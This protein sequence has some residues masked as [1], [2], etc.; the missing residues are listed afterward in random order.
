[1]WGVRGRARS[2]PRLL[3][4]WAGY[5]GRC[6]ASGVGRS[7]TP[8]C[9]PSGRAAGAGV[10]RPGSDALPPPTA[11]PLGGLPGPVWGVRGRARSDPRLLALWAGCRGRCGASRVGRS[12]TPDCPPFGRAAGDGV[13][14]PGSD[15]LPPPTARPLG[16]LPGPVWGVQGRALSHPRLLALWAGCR[17]RCG[18]SGVGRSPTPDCPPSGRAAGAGVGRPGSGTLPLPTARPLGGLPGPVW[19]VRGRTL[20][21]PRLPALWAGCRGRCGASGVGRSRTPDCPP[22]GRAAG[23]GVGRPGSGPLLARTARPL[24]GLPGPVWGVR[25]RTLSHPRLPSLWAGCRC[26]CGASGVGRAPTPD[27]SPSGRAAGAG[28]GRPGSGALPP[29][30][31]R[32]LGGLPVPVWGVRGRTLSHPR[33]PAL[34]AGCRVRCGASG[35]GRSPTPDCPPSGRAAGAG[36]GRQGSDAPP[37]PTARPLGGLPGPVWGVRGRAL[38]HSQLPALWAGCR[39]RCGASGVGRSPTPDCPP[40]GRAAWAGVGRPGSGALPPP[41]ARPLGGLPGPVWGVRGRALSHPRLLALWAGCRGRGG[42]SRVGRP[43][44][45][46]CPPSGRAARAGV[47]CLGSGA[48]PT[49]TARPLGGLPGPAWGVRGRTLSHPQLPALWAGCRGRSGASGVGRAPTPDCSPSGRAAGAGEGR[50]GSGALPPPAARPLGGLPVPVWGVRGRTLCHPR[51]P[52]LWAGC[53]RRCGASGVGR[54]P[55]PDCPPSGRAAGAG[56]GRPGSGALP[57]PTARPLGGLPGPVWGI[58]GRTL[59]HSQLPALWPGCLGRCGA[60]WVG[61]AP[62]PDCPPSGRA[63]GARVGRPGSGA[64]PPPTARPLGGLPGPVWGVRGRTPFQPRL[65]ALWAGCRGRCGASGVGRS[66]TPDCP[67]SGQAAGAGV[68]RPGSGALPLPTA[69]P[70]GGLPGPV[71][72]VLGRARSHPRMPALWAGCWGPC[73]ASGVGRSPTPDCSPS[74]RAAGAGVGRPGSDALPPPTA[75]PLGGLPRPVW[76]V[77][78]RALSR[79]RLLALWAGCRG[80]CGESGVGRSPTADCPPSGRAAGAGVGRPGSDTPPPPTARPLGGLP[81]PV[82]GVRGRALSQPRLLTLWAGCRGRCGAARVGRPSTPDCPPSGRAAGAGVG[83]PGSDT[84]PPRTAR[85]LGGLPGPVWGVRGR[86]LP[87]PRL[88]ALWAGCRGPCGASGVGR[89]P[90]PDCPPSGRAAWAGVGRPGSGALPPPTARP[91]GGL[92]R[93]VWGVRGRALSRPRLLALWAGCRGRCGACGV[94]RPSNPDCPPSVRAARASVGCPGSGALPPRTARPLGGLPGPVWGVRGRT[95]SDPPLPALLAACQGPCGASGVGRS[96]TPDCSHSGRAARAGVGRP[97]SGALPPPTARPLGGLPGQVWGVRGRTLSH[98]RLPALWAG[99]RGGVGR[100]GSGDLPPPTACPLGGLPG[101]VWGVRGRTLSHPRLPALWAGC[102]GRCGASG[103]GRSPTPE[104]SPSGR[105]AGAG[106]GRLGSDALPPPTARPLGGLPGPVWGVRGRAL[107]HSRLPALWAG[108]RGRC[109][110]SGVGRSPTPDCPPSGRAAGAGVGRPGS[111]AL[112]PPTSRPLGGLPGPVWGVRGRTPSQPRLPALWAGCQGRCGA[113]GVGRSPIPDCSPFGR[114]AGAGVGRPGS[115]A[116]PPPTARPLGGLPGPVWGVWGRTLSHPRLPALWAGCRGWCGA[117]GVGRSPTPTARPLGGLPAPVW[118]VRGR[119]LP[120]PRLPALWAGCRGRCGASGVGHSPTPDC[121]PSGRAAGPVWGVRGRTLSHSRLPALWAGCRGRCGA[122]GVARSPDPDCSP[123]GRAA[124]AGVGR[125]WSDALPTPTARPLCGLPWPVWGVWGRALSDPRLLALWAGCRGRCGAS[126]VGRSP[127]PDCPPSGRAARARVGRPGSGALP[128]MTARTLG[129]LPGQTW[130]VRGRTLS[131]CRLPALW[132]GCRGRCGASGVGRSPTP[133]CSPSGRA[134]RAGVGRPGSD[135]LPPPTARPLGGLPGRCGASGVGRSPTPDCLPS[136]RAAG[137]GVGRPGSGALPP[138]TARP[139]G[140]LPG[141]VW[142]VRGRA[143]SHPR[144]LALWE[145]CRGRCGASGVGRSPTPDCPPSGRAS[146]AGVGRPGSGALPLPTARPLGGLPGQV[147]GV[148]GRTL[149]HSRLLALWPGCRGRCGASGVG[150]SPTADCP[151]SGR[152]A[153]AGV[154]RPG[155]DALPPPTARPLG[156]LPGPV[157]GVQGRAL[158]HPRLPAL[159]AGCRRRCGASGVGHSPTPDCPPSGR[160]AGAGVGRPGSDTPPPPTARSLGGLP[161]PV[162][163]VRGRTLSHSRLPALWAGCLGRCGASGVG[164]A[165]TPDCP[166]SGRAAGADVGRPRSGALPTPTARPLGGLPGPVWGVRGRTP[167]QPRLPALCAGCQGQCRMSGVGRSPSPD[168]SPSGRAAGAGVGRLGSDALPSPNARPLGGLPGP[169]WGVRG[170]AL[171]QPRLLALW[172]GCRGPCGASGVRRSPTPDCLPSGRPAGAGVGSLGS[173]ALPPPTAR[174]LGGLPRPVWGVRGRALSHSRLLALWEGCRGR[175]GWFGVGRSPTP[176]CPPSGRASGAGVGRPGSGALP[177]PTARPLG[178]LPGQVWGVRG[179]TLSHSRLPALWAG[180][181][182]R[183]GASGV[184]RAPTPDCSPSGRAA[185]AGVGRPGSGALPFPTARPLG[186]LPEPVWG[187]RGRTPS[188]TQLP[189]IWAGCQGRC[190]ASGVGR[191]PTPDC[192]PSG[193][194]DGAVVGRPGSGALPPPTARPL[195]GLPGPVWGVRGRALSHRRLPALWAGCR[196]RCGASGVGR[197]PSPDCPP[198]GRATG[199]GVGRP[200]SGALSPPTARPLGGLPGPQW[201]VRGR[202]LSHPRLSALWAGCRGRCG[203]S[204]WG[205]SPTPDCSPFGR[206]AGAGVGRPGSGAL[207]PPTARPLGGLPG[208]QWGVRGRALSHPRLPAL[209]AG[210]RRR[211][212]ASGVGHSPT[213][214]C[215]PSGRAAGAGVGRR[216]SDT[217][218]LPT[219]RPLGGPPG[220]V[221]GVRGRTLPHSR[222]PALWAGCRGRCGASWVGRAPAPDCPPSGRAAGAGVGRPGSGAL[223]TPTAC[224]LCRLPGPVWGV[225]GRVLSHPRLL[226]LLAGCRGRCGASGVGRSPTPDCP[227]SRRAARARVGRPGSGALPPPTARTLG[228]LPGQVWGV[229]GRTLSHCRLPALWA[230]CRGRCGASGVGRSPTPDC[231]PSGR[232]AG[233]GVGR[234]GSDALPPRTAHPLGGLP[235]RCGA[236]GVGRS[237]TPDCLPSG[238]AAGDGVERPGSDALPPPTAR[239]LGGLPGPVW[240]IWGRALS[241]PRLLA[242]WAGCRGRCGAS[243]VGRSPAPDCPPSGWAAG[244]GVR[245]PGSDALPL[246]TARPLG[247]LPVPVWGVRGWAR[248]HPRLLALWAGC[249]GRCGAFGVGRSPTPDCS[250]SGRAAGCNNSGLPFRLDSRD[251]LQMLVRSRVPL[252]W[253]LAAE[254]A[255]LIR[256]GAERARQFSMC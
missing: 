107:S 29:P 147:W 159:W 248:S 77:W 109:G 36:V 172:A 162:W 150:R 49:P 61:R 22:S 242:L 219:A 138:P 171:S 227:P 11:G 156:R 224:P 251:Q 205:R 30:T 76:G 179:R 124:G 66:P 173:D 165:P 63:A 158:S 72:G 230:G 89:S 126:G 209:W 163:G 208:P 92:P 5:R 40:S 18:A 132:A 223:R 86:T 148:R 213:P 20:S 218:P 70:L 187:V 120:H 19:G 196:G 88:P 127:C 115:G 105:A 52:A 103:V 169:V 48:L 35:V 152:A 214:D 13:G 180:C 195:G 81:G 60:S 113:S 161:G 235:G 207:S 232:A 198:S 12:P 102:R 246:P 33:L 149:S 83:R 117:S 104:C 121:P 244:A 160:A 47:G 203:A 222:L 82:W 247:G 157:W 239:P 210:C 204:G 58:R 78:G 225:R 238:R 141:P 31:A 228:G 91:L 97:G 237:P 137:A 28:V 130:G 87:H 193:R 234:P 101:P 53:R 139:L 202:A 135:A 192:S 3:A 56:V 206:A 50:P 151:P 93:P 136:G 255:S 190:G 168:C 116:L 15:A 32:P 194:A 197:S 85:P 122:S 74:G 231:S 96:P 46:D 164:R 106:V 254:V 119:T 4:L 23:A 175:C 2:H 155:S 189:A 125:P 154:G 118:G 182:C 14:R 69:R 17:G 95:L 57:L 1:M 178:G 241:H 38:S 252:Q 94:G 44:T 110:A 166:P 65:P 111:G 51:L 6:G 68:G 216:G 59:S 7:P 45:P 253:R 142:G 200:G 27:C 240:G 140:G 191:S 75:R 84:P 8:D 199:A 174:P 184:G 256:L 100:P 176:D 170:R 16:G 112:P 54:S 62:I 43:S 181:R 212:E 9:S 144:L 220:P 99:C 79:P 25:G 39:G 67:P 71:W 37:P 42:A 108:C 145:G 221:W 250:P 229:R 114:A 34:W 183:C 153:G 186:G 167:F 26:R 73:G 217:P 211:C 236:S 129:G 90:T 201:G 185:G 133:D 98:P 215:P 24:G 134:A 41:T 131:H 128:P 188:H 10:G 226:A 64:L 21:H 123:S 245:R 233:A 243:R 55:T 249:R 143:L 80:R 177:L 146:G